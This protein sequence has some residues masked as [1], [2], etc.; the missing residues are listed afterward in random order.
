MKPAPLFKKIDDTTAN[1]LKKRFS[2]K[3]QVW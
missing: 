2:G 3:K 1:E